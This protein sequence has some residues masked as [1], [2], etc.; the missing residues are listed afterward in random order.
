MVSEAAWKSALAV[1]ELEELESVRS[2]LKIRSGMTVRF[3]VEERS[4]I[5]TL[6]SFLML[7]SLIFKRV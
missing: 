1:E 2:G 3:K 7:G 4:I 6:G 5:C